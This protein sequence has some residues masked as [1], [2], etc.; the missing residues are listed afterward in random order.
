MPSRPSFSR[1]S[2]P[3]PATARRGKRS[4]PFSRGLGS[5]PRLRQGAGPQE[6]L[7]RAFPSDLKS[8]FNFMA[9]PRPAF[10]FLSFPRA[11]WTRSKG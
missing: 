6:R 4:G 2:L 7:K 9:G 11:P 5:F 8:E 10:S 1:L 3:G